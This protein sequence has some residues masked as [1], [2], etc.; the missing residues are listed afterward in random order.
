MDDVL[1][2]IGSSGFATVLRGS[3]YIYPL[4]N[5]AHILGIALLIG[6]IA[7]LDARILGFAR[8]VP[9]AD[10]ARLLLPFTI[11]GLVL[12][13]A[14]GLALFSVKPAEYWSNPVFLTKLGLIGAAIV[15]AS[16]LRLRP[17]WR[18]ALGGGATTSPL[19]F[20]AALSLLLWTAVLVAGRLI[21]F[22]GG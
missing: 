2:A 18:A 4:V 11:G 12:A 10:A 1:A 6:T 3:E 8:A 14:T 9:L 21:A 13:I 7:A 17:A 16:S 15:N 19:R 5:A 20:T 22:F